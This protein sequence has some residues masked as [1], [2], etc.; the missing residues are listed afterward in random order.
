MP[1]SPLHKREHAGPERS[2]NVTAVTQLLRVRAAMG[3][4]HARLRPRFLRMLLVS[5]PGGAPLPMTPVLP[6]RLSPARP[7]ALPATSLPALEWAWQHH[8]AFWGLGRDTAQQAEPGPSPTSRSTRRPPPTSALSSPLPG[9]LSRWLEGLR[10]GRT[11]L[12][13]FPSQ[14]PKSR[15]PLRE[16]LTGGG[17]PST[18]QHPFLPNSPGNCRIR[19]GIPTEAAQ[20]LSPS[21]PR[22]LFLSKAGRQAGEAAHTWAG[23]RPICRYCRGWPAPCRRGSPPG[24]ANAWGQEPKP[25]TSRP[26]APQGLQ[27]CPPRLQG[28]RLHLLKLRHWSAPVFWFRKWGAARDH[29]RI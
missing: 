1:L 22:S 19:M 28:T 7:A 27:R 14:L 4:Q 3:T 15:C 23:L 8:L 13:T 6:G 18:P 16:P 20:R 12:G 2:G 25:L 10:S 24:A 9:A 29:A 21:V 11:G 5:T 17:G 26:P